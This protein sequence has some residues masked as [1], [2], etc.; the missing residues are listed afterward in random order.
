M[1]RESAC[2][3]GARTETTAGESARTALELD[4]QPA[5]RNSAVAC[6]LKFKLNAACKR[7]PKMETGFREIPLPLGEGAA[8]RRVRVKDRPSSGPSGH[9]LP[10]GEGPFSS[11]VPL[12]AFSGLFPGVVI[13]MFGAKADADHGSRNAAQEW[14]VLQ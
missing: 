7:S 9:L 11:A 2:P 8:K 5:G 10:E 1:L 12:P 3:F 4:S 13:H 14:R 6:L